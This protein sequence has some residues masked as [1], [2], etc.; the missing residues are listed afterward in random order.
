MW[1]LTIHIIFTVLRKFHILARQ[2]YKNLLK[3]HHLHFQTDHI[4]LC[5][6]H[7][8]L[9]R[10]PE[11]ECEGLGYGSYRSYSVICFVHKRLQAQAGSS[12]NGIQ[13][14]T[15]NAMILENQPQTL[16]A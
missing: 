7:M 6:L 4:S 14:I 13:E 9:F 16:N 15:L 2:M 3:S 12:A 8:C 1:F 5:L 10:I 11:H